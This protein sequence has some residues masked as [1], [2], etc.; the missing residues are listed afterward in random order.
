MTQVKKEK[1]EE[2]KKACEKWSKESHHLE[3]KGIPR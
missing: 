2:I 3:G 1:D